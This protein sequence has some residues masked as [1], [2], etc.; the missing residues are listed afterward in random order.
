MA[1]FHLVSPVAILLGPIL[2]IPVTVAM[3]A[4]FGIFAVGWIVAPLAS[5]LGAVCDANLRFTE[6]CV[7]AAQG[8]RGGHFWVAGP[9]DWW[10]MVFY[11]ALACWVFVPRLV[12]PPRWRGALVA[13]WAAAGVGAAWLGRAPGDELHCAFLSVGHGA[14]VV[15]ELPGR[16]TLLY[17][18][19]RLG[20]PIAASRTVAGYLWS[21]GITHLDAVVL[22]H[23]DSDHYSALAGFARAVFGGRGLCF[24]ADVRTSHAGD[25]GCLRSNRAERACRFALKCGAA[26]STAHNERSKRRSAASSA[27]RCP[28][29][30]QRQQHRPGN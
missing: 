8:L 25:D 14:A 16:Q 10:L 21:R 5:F 2:S 24:P 22:S 30:R 27:R 23:A 9:H 20:S 13:M 26:R 4:G 18:A 1:R 3:A 11:A 6:T 28:G 19:G 17:D 12:P 7:N 29:H 15:V